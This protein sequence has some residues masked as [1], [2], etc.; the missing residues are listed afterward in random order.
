MKSIDDTSNFDEFP[1]V[2]LHLREYLPNPGHPDPRHVTSAAVT[3]QGDE[4]SEL[5]VGVAVCRHGVV[6]LWS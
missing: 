5:T 1:D 4:L 6:S 3:S 2:D